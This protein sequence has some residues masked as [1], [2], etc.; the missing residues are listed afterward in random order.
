MPIPHLGHVLPRSS[1]PDIR[2]LL[3]VIAL[4]SGFFAVLELDTVDGSAKTTFD[5]S[6]NYCLEL[7]C[8]L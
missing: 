1:A 8:K 6:S 5:V 7:T 4:L 2:S 3:R